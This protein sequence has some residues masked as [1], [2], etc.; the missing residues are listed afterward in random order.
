MEEHIL[1]EFTES[2]SQ[3]E[4]QL[5]ISNTLKQLDKESQIIL[6]KYYFQGKSV[7]QIA[8]EQ[9]KPV[10]TIKTKLKR[11]REQMKSLL[12]KGGYVYES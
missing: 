4:L 5:I 3:I 6:L 2:F 9:K 10:S 1:G 8:D 11:G 12:E 7:R